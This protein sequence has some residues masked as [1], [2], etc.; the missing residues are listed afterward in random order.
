MGGVGTRILVG[1]RSLDV[2]LGTFGFH[3][4][5]KCVC[6]RTPAAEYI[7]HVFAM[8]EVASAK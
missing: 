1:C 2:V 6:G 5:S 7:E 8:G 3:D 4:P